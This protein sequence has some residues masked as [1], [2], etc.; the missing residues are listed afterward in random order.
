MN[1]V[2]G[3]PRAARRRPTCRAGTRHPAPGAR[4]A[5]PRPR[6]RAAPPPPRLARPHL[7]LV[8]ARPLRVVDVALFYG[9]RS[10]GIRT[11]LDAKAAYARADRRV[12]APPRR[13]RAARDVAGHTCALPSVRVATANGY[14]WPLGTRPA[15]RP[16]ARARARRRAAARPVLGAARA[17]SRVGVPVVMVHHGSLDLDAAAL[18]GPQPAVPA[19]ARRAG[20]AARTRAPTPSCP[21]ATRAPTPAARRRCRCASGSTPRSIPRA[22]SERGEHVLYAGRL[23]REKGVFELL[24]AAARSREP[25]PLWLMGAGSAGRSRRRAHPPARARRAASRCCPLRARPRGAR[26]RLPLR[27]LRGHA[28]RARDVR[29]RRLRG[30]RLRRVDRRVRDRA[31][32]ARCSARSPHTFAPG[33]P[34][35][36]L[37]AIERA[38]AA[39]PDR[40]A[41]ARFAAA[42]RWER[43]FAAELADLE[44]RSSRDDRARPPDAHAARVARSRR[45]PRR[46]ARDA[47]SAA[48]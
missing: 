10:G 40:L 19:R 36:L 3:S 7:R 26:L 24:E 44:G 13:A 14:R 41:A 22:T 27:P 21:P 1:A 32:G 31:R 35:S 37:A 6:P 34:T 18:P 2:G 38:R 20:C 4:D 15:R 23:S 8:T 16:P 25:W 47:S 48:R 42:N 28:G 12:R 30:R 9:E 5:S 39:E 43:A 45:H 46:R 29:A 33:D 11:Y 17:C